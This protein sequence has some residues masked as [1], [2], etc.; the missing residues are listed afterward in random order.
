MK[1]PIQKLIN[2][3]FYRGFKNPELKFDVYQSYFL[4]IQKY[5]FFMFYRG[6]EIPELRI[7]FFPIFNHFFQFLTNY[8]FYKGFTSFCYFLEKMLL[9]VFWLLPYFLKGET[10]KFTFHFCYTFSIIRVF[11]TPFSNCSKFWKM[12]ILSLYFNSS[13]LLKRQ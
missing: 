11:N 8:S 2:L 3:L 12:M 1:N 5:R 13:L 6:N 4:A 9:D 7:P 10:V